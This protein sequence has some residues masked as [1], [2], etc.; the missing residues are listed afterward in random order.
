MKI[1]RVGTFIWDILVPI[2]VQTYMLILLYDLVVLPHRY[3]EVKSLGLVVGICGA[4]GYWAKAG[5]SKLA[6]LGVEL[7]RTKSK[8]DDKTPA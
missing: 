4:V 7:I 8:I 2:A 5:A 3:D 1:K 6:E